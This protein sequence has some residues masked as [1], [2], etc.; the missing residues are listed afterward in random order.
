[1]AARRNRKTLANINPLMSNNWMDS[2]VLLKKKM[3]P[4]PF[5]EIR[6]R[7]HGLGGHRP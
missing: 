3:R 6:G 5:M 1:M 4:A 2:D 7:V